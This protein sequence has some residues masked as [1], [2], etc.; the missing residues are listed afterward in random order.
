[1]HPTQLYEAAA[2]FALFLILMKRFTGRQP[3]GAPIVEMAMGYACF[4]FVV[5]FFRA[6]N[7]HAYFGLTLSQVISIL[8]FLAALAFSAFLKTR[9]PSAA[10]PWKEPALADE[11]TRAA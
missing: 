2:A 9:R 8:I 1:M 6:D 11:E 3:A 4:R 10:A 5:E 7:A